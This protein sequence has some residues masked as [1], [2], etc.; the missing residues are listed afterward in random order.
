MD[1]TAVD[2]R[3]RLS[4]CEA[5]I[6]RGLA[7]FVDVGNAIR[8]IRDDR[9]YREQYATFE[10]YCKERWGWDRRHANRHVEAA[11]TV[12]ALGSIDPKPENVAQTRELVPLA[13][14]D[15]AAAQALWGE[16]VE[17]HGDKLT[18]KKIKQAVDARMKR[19][20]ELDQ[21]TPEVAEIIKDIDPSD[22]DLPTSTRQLNYLAGVDN[23]E[24]QAEIARRVATGEAVS[25]W[26]ASDQLK[27]ESTQKGEYDY[28]ESLM[29]KA[30]EDDDEIVEIRRIVVAEYLVKRRDGNTMRVARKV[31]LEDG[32][33]KCPACEGLGLA[34]R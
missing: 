22:S 9:L 19:E 10:E 1:N 14:E 17:E 6:E 28:A 5:R 33:K 16:L 18:A 3:S 27:K 2:V 30:K 31:L 29:A 25:V 21:L 34:R 32:Y 24:E 7:T 23:P 20:N 11:E 26:K 15:P 8:E 12:E 4:E 13:K